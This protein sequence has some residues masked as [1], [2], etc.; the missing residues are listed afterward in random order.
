M[1][2]G[3]P[4]FFGAKLVAAREARAMTQ[5]SIA[6]LLGVSKQAVS[7]YELG[8]ASPSPEVMRRITQ[9][10]NLPMHNFLAQPVAR[11]RDAPLFFRSLS[12]ATKTARTRAERRYDWL[13]DIADY[14]RRFV[15]FTP[16]NVPTFDF[17]SDPAA[18]SDVD[19]EESAIAARRFWGLGDGPIS[20]VLWLLE[21]NGVLVSRHALGADTLD[22]FSQWGDSGRTPYVILGSEKGS[23]VRSRFDAAHELGHLVLHKRAAKLLLYRGEIFSLVEKQ[24]HR[25]AGAFLLPASTFSR[26]FRPDLDELLSLKA[27]WKASVALMIKRASHLRLLDPE[28][29]KRLW[30]NL[31]RRRWK[32][33]E[34]LDDDLEPEMPRFLRR[35]VELLV[36][37]RVTSPQEIP[38]RLGLAPTDVEDLVGLPLGY[39]SDNPGPTKLTIP[40]GGAEDK[41]QDGSGILP[42]TKAQ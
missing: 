18:I 27:Q 39:L 35:S 8:S 19:I 14:L 21:N 9:V 41:D 31:T 12:S 16:V 3:T 26:A 11:N 4:G 32:S 20:N 33:H 42:F 22:A 29:E 24:S 28:R 17:S 1:K 40:L 5:V 15:E 25:F 30:I 37:S 36:N 23:A 10:L 6:D 2:P 13:Q 34:P 7:R 38:F